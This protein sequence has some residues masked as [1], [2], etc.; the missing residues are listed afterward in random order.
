[1]ERGSSEGERLPAREPFLHAVPV[2]DSLLADAP[3][4]EHRAA[5][6]RM[7]RR[8]VDEP[9]VEVLDLRAASV[10][11]V[12]AEP[13]LLDDSPQPALELPDTAPFATTA[14]SRDGSP[15][16]GELPFQL[17]LLPAIRHHLLGERPH[18]A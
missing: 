14:V 7:S 5:V 10:D 8:E 13:Q 11:L 9:C 3:A 16:D 15:Y 17:E 2:P 1:M 6:L 4:E 18:G 12:D